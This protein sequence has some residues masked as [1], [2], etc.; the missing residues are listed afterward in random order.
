MNLQ[1]ALAYEMAMSTDTHTSANLRKVKGD[2]ADVENAINEKIMHYNVQAEN[3]PNEESYWLYVGKVEGIRELA[4]MMS[5]YI[6][7]G[8]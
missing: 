6:E 1:E 8:V 3:A 5:L 4:K 2:V 7:P